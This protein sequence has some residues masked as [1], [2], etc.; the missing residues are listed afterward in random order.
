M[1]NLQLMVLFCFLSVFGMICNSK[2]MN[3]NDKLLEKMINMHINGK[4]C[5][6][7]DSSISSSSSSNGLYFIGMDTSGISVVDVRSVLEADNGESIDEVI[8]DKSELGE[9]IEESVESYMMN[10]E[11]NKKMI[12]VNI[13]NDEYKISDDLCTRVCVPSVSAV[14]GGPC[15]S[16]SV[17]RTCLLT[18]VGCVPSLDEVDETDEMG[19]NDDDY[20]L[21]RY[22][23]V[24]VNCVD[25]KINAISDDYE[26]LNNEKQAKQF[27]IIDASAHYGEDNKIVDNVFILLFVLFAAFTMA[28]VA[29]CCKKDSNNDK[30][31]S[32]SNYG[33]AAVSTV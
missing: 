27:V 29:I 20:V 33:S 9:S 19:E 21:S 13:I 12:I 11:T 18:T 7:V 17:C 31:Q 10:Y 14:C 3:F 30:L 24:A 1:N 26:N 32:F 15:C 5:G 28:M 23:F 2:K 25:G 6:L 16:N 4:E 22:L 8:L